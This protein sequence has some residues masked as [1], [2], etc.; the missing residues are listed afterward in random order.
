M[1]NFTY[2]SILII[3]SLGSLTGCRHEAVTETAA[4]SSKGPGLIGTFAMGQRVEMGPVTYVAMETN[5]QT[6]LGEGAN[7]RVPQNRFLSIKLSVTNGAGSTV[8]VPL[9]KLQG[10]AGQT[11]EETTEGM[12]E[13][14]SWFG[15]LRRIQPVETREGVIVFD[16]P[17]GGYKLDIADGDVGQERHAI[18]DIPLQLQSTQ[19]Q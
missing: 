14:P 8:T 9:M 5:W 15:M 18:I 1:S 13:L 2:S 11:Y 12:D 7:P 19:E 4:A 6:K 10:A 3:L 17:L 16:V